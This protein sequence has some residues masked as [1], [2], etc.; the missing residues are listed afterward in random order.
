MHCV[1][2]P[3]NRALIGRSDAAHDASS[4]KQGEVLPAEIALNETNVSHVLRPT[5]VSRPHKHSAP[6]RLKQRCFATKQS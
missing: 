5:V 2:K 3:V 4:V 1:H 6:H